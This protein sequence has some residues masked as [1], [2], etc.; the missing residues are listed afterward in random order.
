M[1]PLALARLRYAGLPTP[2]H[3]VAADDVE[4]GKPDPACYLHAA[5]IVG[6]APSECIVIEDTPAGI[7]AAHAAAI[8][9]VAVAS[10]HPPDVLRGA[11]YRVASLT[12]TR[13]RVIDP[14]GKTTKLELE[15]DPVGDR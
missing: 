10:T 7:A 11:N 6:R 12:D 9:A 8:C 15:L 2:R 3:L 4:Q 14:T 13:L 1:L 5:E